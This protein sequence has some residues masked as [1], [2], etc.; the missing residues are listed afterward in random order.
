MLELGGWSAAY[1]HRRS[2]N[3]QREMGRL[4]RNQGKNNKGR[5]IKF[6]SCTAST[7]VGDTLALNVHVGSR[8]SL[9]PAR[10]KRCSLPVSDNFHL[11]AWSTRRAVD[12]LTHRSWAQPPT[13]PCM[14]A[15][16]GT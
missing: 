15:Y 14:H 12:V 8:F 13:V 4:Q 5:V 3:C 6:R 16:F 1:G 2:R 10:N 7:E 9:T 11:D